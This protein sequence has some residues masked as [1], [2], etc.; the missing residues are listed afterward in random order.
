MPHVSRVQGGEYPS[1][2][3]GTR[4]SYLFNSVIA[5]DETPHLRCFQ[6][7]WVDLAR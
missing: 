5:N 1:S 2:K 4:Q 3:K 6:H 7:T